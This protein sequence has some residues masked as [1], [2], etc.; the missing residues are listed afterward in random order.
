MTISELLKKYR[1]EQMKTQK[2]WV[3]DV[4]SASFY[5]KVERNL[6][7]IS[8]EDLIALLHFNQIS[9]IDFFGKLNQKDKSIHHRKLEI[10]RM[11]NEA[12]YRNSKKELQQIRD[13]VVESDLPNKDNEILII[14]AYVAVIDKDIT[15]LDRNIIS[16][17]KE[18]VFNISNFDEDGLIVYCNFMS[19]YDLNSNLL[20]SKKVIKQFI[21]SSSVKIQKIILGIIINML[22]FCIQ[23]KKF[24][25]TEVF[26]NYAEQIKAQPDIFFYKDIIPIFD[27]VIK[28]HYEHKKK[29]IDTAMKIIESIKLAGMS[30]YGKDLEELLITNK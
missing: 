21:G 13:I 5:T 9:V 4:I 11:A 27:N 6:S 17:M 10:S 3:G 28:Y 19:F 26:I 8:V 23:N 7:R 2:Q 29:Y 30:D 14:D 20:L 24:D 1:I 16:K 18:K 22:I 25:E 15:H 12:Y